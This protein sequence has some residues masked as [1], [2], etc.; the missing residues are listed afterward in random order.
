MTRLTTEAT[1]DLDLASLVRA[2][3]VVAWPQGA[4]EP[5]TLIRQLTGERARIGRFSVFVGT[6]LEASLTPEM[7]DCI[8]FRTTGGTLTNHRLGPHQQ[9]IPAHVSSLPALIRTRRIPIDV[10]LIKVAEHPTRRLLSL[11][12]VADYIHEAIEVARVVIAEISDAAP[13]VYGDALLTP[14]QVDHVVRSSD[15]LIEVPRSEPDATSDALAEHVAALVPDGAVLQLG[16]GAIPDAVMRRLAGHRSIGIHSGMISDSIMDLAEAGV[17]D[18]MTKPVDRGLIVTGAIFGTQALYDWVD[19]NPLVHVRRGA[20][21]HDR[22]VLDRFDAFVS[23]NSAIEVDLTG[24][25]NAEV[26][27]DRYVGAIGGHADYVRAAS[28]SPNGRSIIAMPSAVVRSGISRIVPTLRSGVVTTSRADVDTVVTEH[29]VAELRGR[30]L[31]ERARALIAIAH[32]T[33]RDELER[34][35]AERDEKGW[36]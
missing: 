9:V 4:G 1:G 6:G 33:M 21:L 14:D 5:R 2:G 10:V 15:P 30:T 26:L 29:G 17:I 19:G 36:V 22:S 18:G 34:Y 23:I 31:R 28:R 16:W 11:G 24:Q 27:G 3:D 12:P 35:A 25:I 20:Y 7:A 32:P 8:E 13:F